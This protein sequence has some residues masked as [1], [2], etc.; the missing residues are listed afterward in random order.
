MFVDEE[1]ALA[2]ILQ[3]DFQEAGLRSPESARELPEGG[4]HDV[5]GQAMHHVGP[6]DS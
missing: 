1:Q 3:G 5:S 2:D 4:D 6:R